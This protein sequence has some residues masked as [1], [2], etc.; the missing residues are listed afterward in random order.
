MRI[1]SGKYKGKR[2]TAPKNLPTRPTTDMHKEALFNVLQNYY[3]F[4]AVR[5]LDLFA[6]IG[7]LT[8]EFASR[9]T[10]DLTGV[11]KHA[12]CVKFLT[13]TADELSFNIHVVQADVFSFLKTQ[14]LPYDIIIADPPYEFT[15]EDYVMLHELIISQKL[16]TTEGMLV[17]EH[18]KRIDLSGLELF[19]FKRTYGGTTF[20][21]F[22]P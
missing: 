7:G 16:L 5:V 2:L 13:K 6:G 15:K 10:T 20:S 22:E 12:G 11:D 21:F 19:S 1:I 17:I 18:D 4:D 14:V 9:G 3:N 8:F